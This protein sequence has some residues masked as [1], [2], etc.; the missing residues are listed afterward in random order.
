MNFVIF[1]PDEL[2]A[3]ACGCYGHPLQPTP[4]LDRLAA[5]GTR[6]EQ[7]HVQHTVCSPSRCSMMTGWYPHTSGHRTLWHLLRP[8]EPHLLRYLREAGYDVRWYGKNDLLAADSLPLAATEWGG[9]AAP[10]KHGGGNP[11]APSDPRFYSF[12]WEPFPHEPE[13]QPD[14]AKV[15]RGIDFL[16]AGPAQPFC[17]YLP[18]TY[19]HCPYAA[20][21]PWHDRYDPAT[22]PPLR[23][24]CADKPD[25]H[26]LIRRTRRLDQ[27]DDALLRQINAVYLGM[28]SFVDHWLGQLLDTLDD[29]GL[30]DDTAVFFLSDH[31]DWAGDYGL[32]EKWPSGLDDT[33][34]RV[35]FVAR[36]PGGAAG[37]VVPQITE[38]FDLSAT[39]LELAGIAPRHTHF[40][41]SLVPQLHGAAGDPGRAA[42]AAGGYDRHE[43][44]C[45]EGHPVRDAWACQPEAIYYPKVTLQQTHPASVCRAQMIR[46]STHKLIVRPDGRDELYDLLAD[47]LELHNLA[48]QP[49][50]HAVQHQLERRLLEHNL[51]V[52]DVT[53]WTE[54]PRGF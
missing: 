11:F 31:G 39:V 38:L 9:G 22:V 19:P 25:F 53:P 36:I 17:L 16:R 42:F 2:R 30:A 3:E 29:T 41:R 13:A 32:V 35:P 5:G 37:H 23:P 50:H 47:P 48:G 54:D 46:T 45:F 51:T 7:C 8:H 28:T 52:S 4:Q 26:D 14:A 34:T 1:M 43:P 12:L 33:L 15:R 6:F 20:P 40:A 18:L 49:A 24:V 27:C 21:Q 44:H 10:V